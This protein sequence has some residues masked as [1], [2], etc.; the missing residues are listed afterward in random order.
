MEHTKGEWVF[1]KN[2][3]QH[4]PLIESKE[5]DKS[6]ALFVATALCGGDREPNRIEAE[7][8]ARLIASAPDLLEA[9]E[10]VMELH[11]TKNTYEDYACA[12]KEILQPAINKAKQ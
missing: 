7:A 12:I 8:N 2:D 3:P 11:T 4:Q 10:L 6:G 9:C 1:G 5:A